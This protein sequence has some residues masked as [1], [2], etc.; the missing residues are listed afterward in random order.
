MARFI[1]RTASM[2]PQPPISKMGRAKMIHESMPTVARQRIAFIALLIALCP[3][4][5]AADTKTAA[6]P[7]AGAFFPPELVLLAHDR[8][9]LTLEQ[10]EAFHARMEKTKARSDELRAKLE[11][12]TATLAMLAKQERADEASLVAQLDKV[13]DVERELKH[14]HVGLVVAIKNLLTPEQQAKL[15]EIA[16]DGGTQ[17]AEDTRKRLSE[18]VERVNEGAHKWADSGRDPADILRTM[19]EKFK[20]LIEAGKVIEAEAELDRLLE[21]LKADAK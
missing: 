21:R 17:L 14:L 12:E 2:L 16:K 6:D 1:E 19:A 5:A 11:R 3:L 8:I 9:A 13:L 7:F 4:L 10:R 18:K 15:R 20:H